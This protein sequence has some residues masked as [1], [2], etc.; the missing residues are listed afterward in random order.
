M[1][2][3]L[4]LLFA[5]LL[6]FSFAYGQKN[7]KIT[8]G[9]ITEEE[10]TLMVAPQDTTAEAYVLYDH[11]DLDFEYLDNVGPVRMEHFHR[12]LK[13]LKPSSFER[14]NISIPYDRSYQDITDL[15]AVV[16]L[17]TGGAY[18]LKGSDFIREKQE[19]TRET[20]KFTFP[21]IVPGAIIEY[22]FG[23]RT[24][25]ITVPT[26]YR[27]QEDIPVRRAEYTAMIPVYY[28]YISL[29]A[30]GRYSIND[31]GFQNRQWGPKFGTGQAYG[32]AQQ[33]SHTKIRWAMDDIAAYE[34]QPYSNNF[35]DYIP[36]VRLQ[37]Q[38]VDYP[39]QAPQPVFS[40]WKNTVAELQARRDFGKYYRNKS[41]YNR[42]WKEAEAIVMAGKTTKERIDAAYYFIARRVSWNDRYSVLASDSPNN[43]FDA[44]SGNGADLSMCLLALLNEA[45]I[46]A[47]PLL[48]SLRDEGAP[49]E[50]YPL[51]DQ[52][53]H[54]MVY[55]EVDGKPYL[56]DVNGP[57]R[58][59]GLPRIDALNHRG[60][61]ADEAAPRWVDVEVPLAR[62]VIM[63]DIK[64]EPSGMADVSLTTRMDSYYGFSSRLGLQRM[65]KE[66]EAPLAAQLLTT[67]PEATVV[68]HEVVDGDTDP[69]KAL[70]YNLKLQVPAGAGSEDYLY[71][72]PVMI[73]MLDKTLD[74][75]E[76]RLYP[77]DFPY[78]WKQQ[79]VATI[80]VPEGYAVEE[81]PESIRL[82]AE[83]GGMSAMY[84]AEAKPNGTVSVIFNVQLDRTV[85]PPDAYP[86]LRDMY[87]RIIELQESPIV[88]KRAK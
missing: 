54:F 84:A 19:G 80:T 27:F 18:Q 74:D 30:Q 70:S 41:N 45:G 44:G 85:Y 26:P 36:G 48:V 9:R 72:L 24:K 67:F 23:K 31:V 12:R 58:P 78:P 8:F 16:H 20:L 59:P 33:T 21:Q 64:L 62:Q 17:P 87:R 38:S 39:G 25:N 75:V 1:H 29:G 6:L 43:I 88:F 66:S 61:V 10:R 71:V 42:L 57:S 47:Y 52:F 50:V 55:T 2:P 13:L 81:L 56:L 22:T 86:L 76:Q 51:L 83:D 65:T 53:D 15:D 60:W 4:N 46:P 3:R 28:K 32:G 7:D 5:F 82:V 34:Y 14:A 35:I 11:L 49:I 69:N 68:S 40:D 63:A 37:L 77:I 79:Y 73:A